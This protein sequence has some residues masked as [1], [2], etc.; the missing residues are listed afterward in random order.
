M[1]S[2]HSHS[3]WHHYSVALCNALVKHPR[4]AHVHYLMALREQQSF[5]GTEELDILDPDV[6]RSYLTPDERLNRM[7]RA[8]LFLANTASWWRALWRQSYD[9]LHVQSLSFDILRDFNL[10]LLSW[11]RLT[12]IPIVRTVHELVMPFREQ[13]QNRRSRWRSRLE[14]RLSTKLIAHDALM[15]DRLQ[16]GFPKPR[17]AITVIPNGNWLM[18]R[19]YLPAEY[20]D[21]DVYGSQT[22]PLVLFLGVKRHKGLAIFLDAWRMVA[23]DGHVFKALLTGEVGDPDLL[24]EARRLPAVEV[25][26]GYIPNVDLWRCFA[27]ASF[28]VMPYLSGATSAAVH[29]AYAFKRPVIASDLD[30]FHDVVIPGETG[31]IVPK[32]D[33]LAL[34]NAIVELGNDPHRC[35]TLGEAGFRLESSSRYD[36]NTI[37]DATVQ[38]Y[39]DACSSRSRA[40][41]DRT[42]EEI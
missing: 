23:A 6:D 7:S 39:L 4:V 9:I 19:K 22:P 12:G 1:F 18:F 29:L 15:G 10:L 35:R 28:V 21:A 16:S 2:P 24:D 42:R 27:R 31:L 13:Q 14:L 32:G 17:R 25:H 11:L 36:W 34:K 37:A 41:A 8:F 40:P 20:D 33:P 3:G 30:C 26:G 38:V 5:A